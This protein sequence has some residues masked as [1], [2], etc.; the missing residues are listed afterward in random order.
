MLSSRSI[1]NYWTL[2]PIFITCTCPSLVLV[3]LLAVSTPLHACKSWLYFSH[4]VNHQYKTCTY[5]HYLYFSHYI[6]RMSNKADICIICILSL[7]V[8]TFVQY[9][10]G[11]I[12]IN[13]VFL[14][15]HFQ[16]V[17]VLQYKAGILT[18]LLVGIFCLVT[19]SCSLCCLGI[20]P[21]FIKQFKDIHHV[22]PATGQVVGVY[23]KL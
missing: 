6:N 21:L 20:I 18:W 8:L 1:D 14:L 19:L 10:T 4:H 11:I 2:W 3:D 22:N 7:H 5:L 23:K 9:K 16:N 12:I 15:F 17:T 13:F